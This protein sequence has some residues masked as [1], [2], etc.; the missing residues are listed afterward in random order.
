MPFEMLPKLMVI[1]LL[2]FCVMWLNLFPVKSGI[3]EQYS[4]RELVS[5]HK[6]DATLH[7]KV[8]FRAY[9][10]VHIDLEIMNTM[11]PRTKWAICLGPTRNLQGSYK[12]MSL[13]TGKKI[14]RRKFTEMPITDCVIRQVSKLA[15]KDKAMSGVTFMNKYGVEYTFNDEEE[16]TSASEEREL[17]YAPFPDIP[18]E[19]PG[20]L[21]QHENIQHTM[22]AAENSGMSF[23]HVKNHPRHNPE[24]IEILD[25]DIDDIT[26][27]DLQT[28]STRI[29]I[30]NR[31]VWMHGR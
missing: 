22:L 25:D 2:H 14:V 29:P 26:Y 8:P 30:R 15:L 23:D 19:A 28:Q 3:S 20:M 16:M 18:A 4:P 6:L 12:F 17:A 11:E 5:R 9:C 10:E 21:T 31:C 13:S 27:Q 1:K 24:V 7:C